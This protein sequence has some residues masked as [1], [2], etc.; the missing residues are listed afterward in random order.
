[1]SERAQSFLDPRSVGGLDAWEGF[2]TQAAYALQRFPSWFED[3]SC[4]GFQFERG[5]DVDVFHGT[6]TKVHSA[7]LH[8][9]KATYL[10]PKEVGRLIAGFRKRG[11]GSRARTF[12]IATPR[13]HEVV[14]AAFDALARFK[15]THFTDAEPK[16][17][18]STRKAAHSRLVKALSLSTQDADFALQH[19]AFH[20]SWADATAPLEAIATAIGKLPE[21]GKYTVAELHHAARALQLEVARARRHY[22]SREQLDALIHEAIAASRAGLP[23]AR[24]DVLAVCHQSLAPVTVHPD[25]RKLWSDFSERR[26]LRRT[27]DHGRLRRDNDWSSLAD[28]VASLMA[29]DGRFA[30]VLKLAATTPIVYYGFPHIPLAALAGFRLGDQAVGRVV[31]NDR[32]RGAFEWSSAVAFEPLDVSTNRTA[33]RGLALLRVSV[34]N[35]VERELCIPNSREPVAMELHAELRDH[36]RGVVLTEDQARE[37]TRKLRE[38]LDTAVSGKPDIQELHI[39]AA[40][41][42]SLAFRLGQIVS[43]SAYPPTWIYNFRLGDQPPYSWGLCLHRAGEREALWT[44][45][46]HAQK[47]SLV[48]TTAAPQ[49]R[50]GDPV[51]T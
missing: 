2:E 12:V 27:I 8:Q 6:N 22:W 15:A 17:R 44:A 31:D 41:P 10:S 37:Y 33:E 11:A 35:L 16:E 36:Y 34:S 49:T 26:W 14:R 30:E 42:V 9:V 32:D 51:A 43:G 13:P 46:Q 28:E 20:H 48:E 29:P 45:T 5:E 18:E 50:A 4:Q 7:V 39:Y 1:M 25:P 21:C 38:M 19:V 3:S 40:V 23:T 24:G 47:E